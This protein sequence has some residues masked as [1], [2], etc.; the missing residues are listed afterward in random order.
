MQSHFMT[1]LQFQDQLV[2]KTQLQL[3]LVLLNPMI[4]NLSSLNLTC[5]VHKIL[6]VK[7]KGLMTLKLP[8]LQLVNLKDIV[9][10]EILMYKIIS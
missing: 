3:P 1:V 4:V 6:T 10:L 7:G 8:W 2:R 9:H 5:T